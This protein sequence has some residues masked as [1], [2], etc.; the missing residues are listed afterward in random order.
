MQ[1]ILSAFA[2]V[3]TVLVVLF[4]VIYVSAV[5]L[6]T[7]PFDKGRYQSALALRDGWRG[8]REPPPAVCRRLEP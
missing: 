3:A 1:R 2:W 4:G 7:A 5:W 6:V 8:A